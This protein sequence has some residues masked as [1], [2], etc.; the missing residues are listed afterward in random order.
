MGKDDGL[1]EK[2]ESQEKPT[3]NPYL[4]INIITNHI[5]ATI[6]SSSQ[7]LFSVMECWNLSKVGWCEN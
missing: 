2:V 1:G 4:I 5:K 7:I 6:Y 3:R